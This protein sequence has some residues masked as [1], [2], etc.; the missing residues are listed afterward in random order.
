MYDR[1]LTPQHVKIYELRCTSW[2]LACW[3]KWTGI[4]YFVAWQGPPG[5]RPGVQ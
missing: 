4:A 2:G 5:I 1:E 3:W